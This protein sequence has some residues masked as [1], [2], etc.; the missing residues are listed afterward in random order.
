M[1]E[2]G[3]IY[4]PTGLTLSGRDRYVRH[5]WTFRADSND[6]R[7]HMNPGVIEDIQHVLANYVWD[8]LQA[9]VYSTSHTKYTEAQLLDWV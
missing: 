5:D 9:Q 4:K 3:G 7:L 2:G 1:V 8:G 6:S